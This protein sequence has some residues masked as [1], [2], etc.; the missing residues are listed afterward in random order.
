MKKILLFVLA[1][2]LPALCFAE[3]KIAW[4]WKISDP[5]VTWVRYRVIDEEVSNKWEYVNRYDDSV[6]SFVLD[7]EKNK[8]YTLE[9]QDSYDGVWWSNSVLSEVDTSMFSMLNK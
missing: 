6:M 1:L 2:L 8:I 7:V 3:Y 9:V 4:I 5:K